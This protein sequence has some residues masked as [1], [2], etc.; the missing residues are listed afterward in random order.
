MLKQLAALTLVTG[1]WVGPA[2]ADIE[3]SVAIT[4]DYIDKGA[5]QSDGHAAFQAGLTWIAEG[6]AVP[7]G[8][9]LD[10]RL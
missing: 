4:T 2:L 1:V 7:G 6:G 9:W 10:R 5:S 3:G 8:G